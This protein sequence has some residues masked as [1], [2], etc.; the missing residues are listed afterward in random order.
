MRLLIAADD[1]TGALDT[2]VKL[3]E[4]G[5]STA[6]ISME[7]LGEHTLR[8][9]LDV[10]VV[11]TETRHS[12]P[13]EAYAVVYG[14]VKM[15]CARF[16]AVALYKKTDSALRGNV[17]SELA[18]MLNASGAP[19][20]AFVPALPSQGRITVQG[21]QLDHGKPI[22]QSVFALD[23]CD[24]VT[25]ASI[26]A[27]IARQTSIRTVCVP[28]GEGVPQEDAQGSAIWI[29]DS[30]T[31][32][33]MHTV[34]CGLKAAGRVR[35]TAGCAGFAQ[36]LPFMLGLEGKRQETAIFPSG[37]QC[38]ICGSVNPISRRQIEVAQRAG[39]HVTLLDAETLLSD[40][41]DGRALAERVLRSAQGR[42][43]MA[44][45]TFDSECGQEKLAY[46][47]KQGIAPPQMRQ[48]ISQRLGLLARWLCALDAELMPMLIGGDTLYGFVQAMGGGMVYPLCELEPGCVLA[49]YGSTGAQRWMMTKSGGVGGE[50]VL[51]RLRDARKETTYG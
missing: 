3:A 50:D 31:L 39:M 36:Q 47:K 49:R 35:V 9:P 14:L 51:L 27:V 28:A 32:A 12:A 43:S 41:F 34:A 48:L 2:G 11:S 45:T 44:V 37:R 4:Q 21:C 15:V 29:Y 6:V 7:E 23:C 17:G 26:P 5:V 42:E 40:G 33:Q 16:P 30:E 1:Y 25:Q 8:M 19:T 46:A 22:H 38:V 13:E 18:A 20:M 24:P 10:L